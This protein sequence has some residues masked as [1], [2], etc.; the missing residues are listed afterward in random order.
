MRQLN[1]FMLIVLLVCMGCQTNDEVLEETMIKDPTEA[2]FDKGE[3]TLS[4]TE[5]LE[6]RMQWLTYFAAKA[7]MADKDV[8]DEV[9]LLLS[10]QTTI[11]LEDL[12]ENGQ[13]PLF[14]EAFNSVINYHFTGVRE[15][16]EP[17]TPPGV[18]VPT[19]CGSPEDL[20][21]QLMSYWL[22]DHCIEI[23]LP[24]GMYFHPLDPAIV[25]TAHPLT[26]ADANYA[27]MRKDDDDLTVDDLT[28]DEI[29][30]LTYQNP[31][32]SARLV[33]NDNP[34]DPKCAYTEFDAIDF[35]E[36]LDGIDN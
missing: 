25:S 22:D 34:M 9:K 3:D 8:R 15:D 4:E 17:K 28:V 27:F 16:G 32:M 5:L 35:E 30:A 13:A 11:S 19:C 2:L 6:A 23:Y 31:I 26:D 24:K 10:D 36:F 14:V 18:A 33:P 7:I 29:F 1:Y 20:I 12:L 21:A